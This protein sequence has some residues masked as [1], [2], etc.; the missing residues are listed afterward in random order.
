MLKVVTMSNGHDNYELSIKY[1][2]Q[3]VRVIMNVTRVEFRAGTKC[4]Y[5]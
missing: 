1:T 2:S 4:K 5:V 3:R